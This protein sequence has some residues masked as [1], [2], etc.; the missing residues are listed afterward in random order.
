MK[1]P[2]EL[3]RVVLG[4]DHN[5]IRLTPAEFD[6]I[7]EFDDN[8]RYELIE[9]VL[10]VNPVASPGERGPNDLLGHWLWTYRES[11]PQGSSLD[12]TLTEEYIRTGNSRRRADRVIWA[13]LGRQP[14]REV[15]VPTIAV[16]FVSP[17]RRSWNR[18]Y[19]EKRDEYLAVGV[20]EYWVVDRFSRTMTVFRKRQGV[21]AEQ[22]IV[23]NDVYRPVELPGFELPLARLLAVADGW[24]ENE[25]Q[26]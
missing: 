2:S 10:V 26:R 24:S 6:A 14:N 15:D 23:G 16:E 13:G 25:N 9:G 5:G 17:G 22:T 7:T 19:V 8:F 11:H 3:D 18:D 4:S 12:G 1:V 20:V 21:V